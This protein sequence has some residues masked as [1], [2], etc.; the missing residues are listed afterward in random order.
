VHKGSVFILG[1]SRLLSNKRTKKAESI[2]Y[3]QTIWMSGNSYTWPVKGS[4]IFC[5]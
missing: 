4:T 1:L 3:I 2:L 5:L